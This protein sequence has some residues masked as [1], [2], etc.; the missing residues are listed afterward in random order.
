MRWNLK[1]LDGLLL[2]ARDLAKTKFSTIRI[3]ERFTSK[4]NEL[5]ENTTS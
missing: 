1:A 5:K 4:L 3:D 2:A